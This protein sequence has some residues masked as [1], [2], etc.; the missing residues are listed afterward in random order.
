MITKG[1]IENAMGAY[2][3]QWVLSQ[4]RTK[5]NAYLYM[6]STTGSLEFPFGEF[7]NLYLVDS[8]SKVSVPTHQTAK[9]GVLVSP[10][11]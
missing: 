3:Y 5:Y 2:P 1:D 8:R 6:I 4:S 9:E 11:L 10:H 7:L